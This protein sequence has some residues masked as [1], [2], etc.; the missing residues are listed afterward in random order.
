MSTNSNYAS[1][2][3]R[4]AAATIDIWLVL[5]L[6]VILGELLGKIWLERVMINF[7]KD[8]NDKFGTETL[9]NTP[10]HITFFVHSTL[11]F[12]II[13]FLAFLILIGAVYHA[14]LNSS[15]WKGSVG[16]RLVNIMIVSGEEGSQITFGR[17]LA[18]YFLSIMP[19]VFIVYIVAFQVQNNTTFFQTLIGSKVNLVC[20]IIFLLWVQIQAFTKKKMTAY[21]MICKTFLI[22]GRT[23]A[24]FPWSK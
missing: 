8:F 22:N 4:G 2:F 17:A 7:M 21:D 18:H 5:M 14:Y 16:K 20:G 19:F 9:K 24:K 6:R 1:S 11:S 15:A 13:I 10:E 12:C 3:R 23:E